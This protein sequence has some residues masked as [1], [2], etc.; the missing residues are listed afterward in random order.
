MLL[1]IT[2][3]E[4]FTLV[5]LI[6]LPSHIVNTQTITSEI[7]S[8]VEANA[9]FMF[10]L[11]GRWLE[12]QGEDQTHPRFG[13]RYDYNAI[14]GVIS[15]NGIVVIG[16]IRPDNTQVATYAKKTAD[17]V[18]RLINLG[19]PARNITIAGHSKGALI[20]KHV[21][22]LLKKPDLKYGILAGCFLNR[23]SI[24]DAISG[25]FIS[26]VDSIDRIAGSCRKEFRHAKR[27]Q[28]GEIIFDA[29][30]GHGLFFQP[31]D[32]WV[33]KLVEF[34]MSK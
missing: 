32:L 15:R 3:G 16:Q 2:Y 29:G 19:V 11:H 23:S 34:A 20:A 4:L 9:N 22:M 14:L 27:V 33:S 12:T 7:P 8:T 28:F 21:A 13:I 30:K 18:L 6:V 5:M 24:G 17:Q 10:F 25:R 1:T 31:V 26:L